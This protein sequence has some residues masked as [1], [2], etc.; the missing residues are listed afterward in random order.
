MDI[1][2][3]IVDELAVLSESAKG[4]TKELNMVSWNDRPAKFDL[5][6]WDPNHEKMGKG[7]TLSREEAHEL[8]LALAKIFGRKT[9]DINTDL[10]IDIAKD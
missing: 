2:F 3:D 5:R 6:E 7:I 9:S 1:K 8:Y 4:W 10:I